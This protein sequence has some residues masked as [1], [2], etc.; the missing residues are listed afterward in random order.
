MRPELVELLEE[1]IRWMKE[2]PEARR[3]F[4]MWR[5]KVRRG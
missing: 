5:R 2:D 4:E 1:I 3:R